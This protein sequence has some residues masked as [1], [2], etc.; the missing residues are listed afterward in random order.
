MRFVSEG[1]GDL[2]DTFGPEDILHYIYAVFHSP[3]Y[4]ERY[5]QFLRSDFPRV[6]IPDTPDM[7]RALVSVG[8]RLTDAHLMNSSAPGPS[9]I[10]FPVTGDNIIEKAHPRYYAPGEKPPGV[11]SPLERGRV[12]ISKSNRRSGKRGQYFDGVTPEI[13]EFRIGGY[14]PMR[15]WLQ[16][17]QGRALTFDDLGHYRRI[18]SAIQDTIQLM[19]EADTAITQNGGLW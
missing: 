14:Q 1:K 4:R 9:P 17:R 15:K 2:R 16:D 18:A 11:K 6:P 13:W 3:T 19:Q 12:Y 5:D 10:G 7:F 8:Q